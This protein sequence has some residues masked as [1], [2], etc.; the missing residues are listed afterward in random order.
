MTPPASK[1]PAGARRGARRKSRAYH[2]GDLRTALIEAARTLL[3]EGGADALT[4]RGVARLAGVSQTAPYRHFAS[5]HELIAAVAEEGFRRLHAEMLRAASE[6]TGRL[7]LQQLAVAYVRFALKRPAEYRIMFG[8]DPEGLARTKAGDSLA[9]ASG[10]LM[11]LLR[12]GIEQLQQA[13]AVRSGDP[14]AMALAAWALVHGLAML[15]LDGQR[16][17]TPSSAVEKMVR[18]ATSLMMFGMSAPPP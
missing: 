11:S 16:P 1:P 7:G 5:H 10:A 3:A 6:S 2:H 4:L 8:R 18:D 15:I 13:G 17:A 14:G 12:G 9:E